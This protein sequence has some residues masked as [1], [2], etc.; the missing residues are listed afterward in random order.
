M[1]APARPKFGLG[2]VAATSGVLA[3]VGR[4]GVLDL[5]ARHASGDWG[6]LAAFD[7]RENE[8]ALKN[9]TRLFSSYETPEGK[10]WVIT[11]AD[12]SSTTALLPSEY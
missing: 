12:R 11:E 8:R 9:G 5:V 1:T 6:D 3:L 4:P 7:R 2:V 10:V